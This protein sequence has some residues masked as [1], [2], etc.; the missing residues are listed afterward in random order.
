MNKRSPK[1]YNLH[2]RYGNDGYLY[3]KKMVIEKINK[4]IK[5]HIDNTNKIHDLIIS[6]SLFT[7]NLLR[8]Y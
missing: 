6:N 3:D 1:N 2:T 7:K 8:K 4:F 5:S